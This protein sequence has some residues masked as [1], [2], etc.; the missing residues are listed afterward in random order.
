[1]SLFMNRIFIVI[2][3]EGGEGGRGGREG[4][5]G[6]EGGR[7]GRE[8]GRESCHHTRYVRAQD[9]FTLAYQAFI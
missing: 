1:M 6:G 7:G 2:P 8:G 4:R 3:Y 5:E 9:R